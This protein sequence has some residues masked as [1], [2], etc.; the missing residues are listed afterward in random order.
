MNLSLGLSSLAGIAAIYRGLGR[1][2]HELRSWRR[3]RAQFD[4]QTYFRSTR[5]PYEKRAL[6]CNGGGG[7]VSYGCL[8]FY[9]RKDLTRFWGISDI[10]LF[11][12]TVL[13][14]I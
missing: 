7:G 2:V 13:Y 1:K 5:A 4:K 6:S 10:L 3:K 11:S 8:T 14:V 12:Y 9:G